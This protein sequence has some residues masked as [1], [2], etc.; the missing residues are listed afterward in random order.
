MLTT[1]NFL[2]RCFRWDNGIRL[3]KP[4]MNLMNAYKK[5]SREALKAME[6][7]RR[8]GN[9]EWT[10]T[11]SYYAKYHMVYAILSRLGVKCENH[12]CSIALFEY[13]FKGKVSPT[14]IRELKKSKND[15]EETQYYPLTQQ[16]DLE[17]IALD[18]K[19]SVL[20]IEKLLDSLDNNQISQL[21][22][23]MQLLKASP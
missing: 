16:F 7:M 8:D 6:S 21:Q 13:L 18:T 14:L 19:K 1:E 2:K 17:V 5:K 22:Q 10:I 15:R 3:D 9:P 23:K 20:E 11:T 4:S 12:A